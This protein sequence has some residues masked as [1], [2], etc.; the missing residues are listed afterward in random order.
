[1]KMFN[2]L[3]KI[4]NSKSVKQELLIIEDGFEINDGKNTNQIKWADIEKIDAFKR[5]LISEDQI[6][7]EFETNNGH[8][9]CSE[10]YEGW[11][12]FEEMLRQQINQIDKTW[13]SSVSYPPFEESRTTIFLKTNYLCSVCGEH[14]NEWPALTFN[15]PN[16]YFGLNEEEKNS[17]ATIDSDFCIIEYEDQ[18]DRFIRVVLKQKVNDSNQDL[19]YGL[20]VSLSEKNYL[21]YR[22]NYNSE[23]HEEQ[24]FGWLNS[25]IAEYSDTTIIP[26]TLVTKKG[27]ERPEIFPHE[28]FQHQFVTDY[29]NGISKIEAE[30]RIHEMIKETQG[31]KR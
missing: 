27:N 15:S 23:N 19:E 7:L 29:Y 20:W 1:M 8:L 26:T 3:K 11:I 31:N 18:T 25:R 5:D 4:S 6:C 9:F 13:I 28:D 2:W 21:N 22:D 12:E 30:K 24:Y 10:D 16:S 17:I 14:H